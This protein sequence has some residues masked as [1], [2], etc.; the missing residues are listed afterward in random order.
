MNNNN[1]ATNPDTSQEDLK[2]HGVKDVVPEN[3]E[4]YT[5]DLRRGDNTDENDLPDIDVGGNDPLNEDKE[6]EIIDY[7]KKNLSSNDGGVVSPDD[8]VTEN[9]SNGTA[10]GEPG[11]TGIDQGTG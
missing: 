8:I 7:N 5:I 1:N 11:N 10:P 9:E 6:A 3:D 4:Y 2:N